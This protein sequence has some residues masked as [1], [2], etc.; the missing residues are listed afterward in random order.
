MKIRSQN[1]IPPTLARSRKLA[2]KLKR[3][4]EAI[5][6]QAEAWRKA[7][8]APRWREGDPVPPLLVRYNID[9]DHTAVQLPEHITWA[10]INLRMATPVGSFDVEPQMLAEGAD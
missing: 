4:A 1:I 3:E 9:P 6:A 7:F 2:R 5:D 10:T 8:R